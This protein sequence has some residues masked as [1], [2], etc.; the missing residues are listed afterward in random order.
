M[1]NRAERAAAGV[2]ERYA[3]P[4]AAPVDVQQLAGLMGISSIVERPGHGDGRLEVE[5]GRTKIVVRPRTAPARRR[6]TIAHELGHHYLRQRDVN[7]LAPSSEERFCNQFAAALLMPGAWTEARGAGEEDLATLCAFATEAE[8]S[9]SAA[10]LR[11]RQLCSWRGSLLRWRSDGITW[12]LSAATGLPAES[13]LP[14]SAPATSLILDRASTDGT[15]EQWVLPLVLS[16][17][18]VDTYADVRILR[19][20]AVAFVDLRDASR[21]LPSK[22]DRRATMWRELARLLETQACPL[23]PLV[24]SNQTFAISPTDDPG[25]LLQ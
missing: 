18:V 11:L 3:I 1:R 23:N 5:R 24:P 4:A 8:V 15:F 22:A 2:L 21:R 20:G 7:D 14:S 13:P 17:R 12:H 19:R 16:G 6:F 25:T 10:L 9:L